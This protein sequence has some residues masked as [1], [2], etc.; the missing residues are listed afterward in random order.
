[1]SEETYT[2]KQLH[3]LIKQEFA[4]I[5]V[6]FENVNLIM[7]EAFKSEFIQRDFYLRVLKAWDKI[8]KTI[9]KVGRKF[10]IPQDD[11]DSKF[12]PV[13]TE[14]EEIAIANRT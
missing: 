13:E 14:L 1:M 10:S 9:L 4:K 6:S 11:P 8:H 7:D 2:K 12:D 3:A 5:L